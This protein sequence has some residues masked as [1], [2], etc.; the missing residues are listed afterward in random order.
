M[1]GPS[2]QPWP[3][4]PQGSSQESNGHRPA[5]GQ[6]GRPTAATRPGGTDPAVVA[7]VREA[8]AA[9]LERAEAADRQDGRVLSPADERQRARQMIAEATEAWV[10]GRT[11]RG[12]PPPGL[13]VERAVADAV[14][15][16][17]FGLGALQPLVDRD[18]VENI[19]VH[20][21]DKVAL[22]LADGSVE[23]WPHPIAAS[24]ADLVDLLAIYAARLGQTSREFS[25]A[26]PILNLRLP[27][28]GP[29]GSR[30][31]AVMEVTDR[32]H[33]TIRRHRLPDI[34]LTDLVTNGTL[35]QPLAH[36]LTAAVRAGLNM[37]I[38]GG[39][40]A[41]KTTLLRAAAGEI[42]PSEHVVTVEDEYELGL[43][44]MPDRHPLV[45]ALEAR[46]PNA[47]GA[48][49][50]D[51]D[52]L[53]KQALRHSPSRV[54]VGEVRGGEVTAMLRA[55][56]NGAAGGMCTLHA[57]S[58][59]AVFDR[60]AALGQ[61]A[62]PPLPI[63]A[64]FRW[65]ASAVDL[66]VHVTKHDTRTGDGGVQRARYVSEVL[67]VGQV[68]DAGRPDTTRVFG[69]PAGG[70]RAVPEF[71]PSPQMSARLQAAGFDPGWLHGSGG[72]SSW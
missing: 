9:R 51:M 37:V 15:D 24:N 65:I 36:F 43:H 4:P 30:L 11:A 55:L 25:T 13:A 29:L 2:W 61:L 66:I 42:G 16:A 50:V 20:G 22:E 7:Q 18:D 70:G 57:V 40:A 54:L 46:Y 6:A 32:P 21:H 68:G 45:T 5:P 38:S 26:S 28:G 44:L 60:I 63:E 14:F 72:G 62:D 17:L 8:V 27:A 34:T 49:A 23:W 64:A 69:P 31:A 19:H 33:V 53:L 3:P 41:G 67:E 52:A 12:L 10:H 39:P 58:A 48:G 59:S 56:G 1:T 47:E 71:P 35:D